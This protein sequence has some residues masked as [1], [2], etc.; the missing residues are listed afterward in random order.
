MLQ[1]FYWPTVQRDIAEFCR[2]CDSCQKTAGKRLLKAPLIPLPVISQPFERI[3]MDI[4]GPL[5]KSRRGHRFVLVVCDYAY[6]TCYLEA[7]SMQHVNAGSVAE[8]LVKF[9]SRVGVPREILTDQ[10]TNFTSQL[11]TELYI[12]SRSGPLHTTPKP[13]A[14]SK[15]STKPLS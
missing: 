4:I 13:M 3:A 8:E 10:G 9:F 1:C 11:L 7:L 6:T 15:G 12:F 14:W 2:R 5:P